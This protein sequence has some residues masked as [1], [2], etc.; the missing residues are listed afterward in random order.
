[1]T[2]SD[3]LPVIDIFAGPGGLG[4]GF[5]SYCD[6]RG[7]N[8]FR[9]AIS[10]EMDRWAH[11]TLTFRAFQRALLRPLSGAE[12][13]EVASHRD[14]PREFMGRQPREFQLAETEAICRTLGGDDREE[15]RER[16]HRAIGGRTDA[17]LI[18]GPPCQAYS[19]AGRSRNRGKAGYVPEEDHRQTLYLEYLQ[20]LADHEPAAF[21]MEN[22][23][24]LTSASLHS[25]QLF[26]LIQRDLQSP[27]AAVRR[28]GRRSARGR[29]EYQL[30]SL[31][32]GRDH[33]DAATT[34]VLRAEHFGVPQARH[35]V[36]LVGIR[37]DLSARPQPLQ[38]S[39]APNVRDV[40]QDLPR[41]RSSISNRNGNGLHDWKETL[42]AIHGAA[43]LR[44]TPQDI[45]SHIRRRL[46]Q[47][48]SPR[49]GRGRIV[50]ERRRSVPL[51]DWVG[52]EMPDFVLNHESRSH[53]PADL[54][55]Y[56]FTSCWGEVRGQSPTLADFPQ[57]L[58][59]KHSNVERALSGELFS[60][61]F[62][63]QIAD[64]PATTITSHIAK[65]GH[66]FIHYDPTQCRSLTVREAAR[67]QTFPD[68]YFFTGPRTSQYHQVG[69]AVPPHLA[70]Q[71][72]G[73]LAH[74]LGAG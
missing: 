67:L 63:V 1:M 55:R 57:L 60:D 50:M 49:A 66:Y 9:L 2:R 27:G 22:V 29:A 26:D 37:S 48:R 6:A 46:E 44:H 15:I 32:P 16:I 19:L 28:E 5:A 35:R 38:L 58:L 17:I 62:R 33:F 4:E 73:A 24:G 10:I 51:C 12:W 40:V 71:I 8:P 21:V 52:T 70:R 18:G 64:R 23:K 53:M 25:Q 43:W 42:W 59:P 7:G 34:Y 74:A 11:S 41:I 47:V 56:F 13:M 45:Q 36:I 69:N 14:G 39:V 31:V 30:F 20:V 61:R 65:D 54:D 68:D 72:A 3:Q